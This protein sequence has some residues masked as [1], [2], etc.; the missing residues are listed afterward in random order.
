M[1]QPEH[2]HETNS[3]TTLDAIQHD[4]EDFKQFSVAE[5]LSL[6]AQI[7]LKSKESPKRTSKDI[8]E[9]MQEA[10]IRSRHEAIFSLERQLS[11]KQLFGSF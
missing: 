5:I 6:K 8:I 7:A 3:S 11:E 10:L 4:I 2:L 9:V 1:T